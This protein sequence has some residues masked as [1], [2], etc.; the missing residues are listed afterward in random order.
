MTYRQPSAVNRITSKST[1]SNSLLKIVVCFFLF[2]CHSASKKVSPAF[3]HWQTHFQI[4]PSER[5]YLDSLK[6]HQL[7]VKFFDIDWD[8]NSQ[9]AIPLAV[10]QT[11]AHAANSYD[12]IPTIFITNRTFSNIDKK[13]I[14]GL[15]GKTKDKIFQIYNNLQHPKPIAE[16]QLDCD[17]T[18]STKEKYFN[19]IEQLQQQL[20]PQN[21]SIS[22]T[23]RL[24]QIKFFKKTGV[25]AV[26]KG[27]LMFYNM[28]D[29]SDMNTSN[30]ILDLDI[31]KKYLVN[32]EH[33]PLQL[34]LALPIFSWGV[35][36]REE[37]MIKLMHNLQAKDLVDSQRF[38]KL[39]KN[40]YQVLKSTYL[41]GYYLYKDDFIRLENVPL[42][43]L[44]KS[45]EQ[46][47][48]LL[49]NPKLNVIFYHLDTTIIQ[50]YPYESLEKL[51]QQLE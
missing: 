20:Q 26:Q 16:I 34:D 44:E 48:P 19:F 47:R 51:C 2:S 45:V 28:G 13:K 41:N 46:T 50:Q 30:S 33:Y 1:M 49:S 39:K 25:P 22:A 15:V 4:H 10:L 14:L 42:S 37:Q 40:H 6:V 36:I 8:A 3:Y 9:Q 31:A 35:L 43:T 5:V 27:V 32:F 7:Y 29:V 12:I 21:I 18:L 24:H 17:W 11:Q 38:L 23:I